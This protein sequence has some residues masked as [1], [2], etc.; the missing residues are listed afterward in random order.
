MA[1]NFVN[2]INTNWSANAAV[3]LRFLNDF[4]AEYGYR[5]TIEDENGDPI[6]NPVTRQ[7]FA[8]ETIQRLIVGVV[9]GY[10]KR[11]AVEEVAYDV[12]N[13]DN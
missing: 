4:C 2:F 13:F 10:R 5:E 6:P 7:E 1:F 11:Q 8:N 9:N 3:K 12:L